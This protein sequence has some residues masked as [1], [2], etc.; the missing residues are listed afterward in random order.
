MFG[1]YEAFNSHQ[2]AYGQDDWQALDRMLKGSHHPGSGRGPSS[3]D[4]VDPDGGRPFLGLVDSPA[5]A[6]VAA[7][8][9]QFVVK[10]GFGSAMQVG[11]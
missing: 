4:P 8:W 11:A 1:R 2:Q 5:G 3:K 10:P 9:T 7:G 6:L